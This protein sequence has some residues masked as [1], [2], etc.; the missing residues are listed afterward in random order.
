L[1][2]PL[3]IF[4]DSRGKFPRGGTTGDIRKAPIKIGREQRMQESHM[5]SLSSYHS[6]ESCLDDPQGSG[7]VLTGESTGAVLSSEITLNRRQTQIQS[8][9]IFNTFKVKIKK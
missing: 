5:K 1:P 6:T 3:K 8:R 7:E 9:K 2:I 4:R